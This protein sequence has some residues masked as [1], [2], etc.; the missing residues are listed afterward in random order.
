MQFKVATYHELA[1]HCPNH[2]RSKPAVRNMRLLQENMDK[3]VVHVTCTW[4]HSHNC[5]RHERVPKS[6]PLQRGRWPGSAQVHASDSW[7]NPVPC[8][9]GKGSQTLSHGSVAV[10]S[11]IECYLPT[12]MKVMCRAITKPMGSSVAALELN[13]DGSRL[14]L[15]PVAPC[16]CSCSSMTTNEKRKRGQ[17]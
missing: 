12:T 9:A 16:S 6:S 14:W 10:L 5:V 11:C 13:T 2:N 1:Y 17:C 15:C 7:P 4:M 8:R 3:R